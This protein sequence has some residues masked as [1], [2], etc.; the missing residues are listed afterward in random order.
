MEQ[1]TKSRTANQKREQLV[2]GAAGVDIHATSRVCDGDI[3]QRALQIHRRNDDRLVHVVVVETGRLRAVNTA[4]VTLEEVEYIWWRRFTLE[5]CA[6]IFDGFDVE[7][8][9]LRDNLLDQ[10]CPLV[11]GRPE[12]KV[13]GRPTEVAVHY[14]KAGQ[15]SKQNLALGWVLRQKHDPATENRNVLVRTFEKQKKTREPSRKSDRKVAKR[16]YCDKRNEKAERLR[17]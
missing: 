1:G 16:R 14:R 10:D 6:Q 3:S 2:L 17:D 15:R 5:L 8:F 7:Q 12:P 4:Q 13:L 9:S 11:G